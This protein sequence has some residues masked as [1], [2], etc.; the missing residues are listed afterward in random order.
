M[1]VA[2]TGATGLLGANLAAL[3]VEAGHQVVCTR[4]ASSDTSVLDGVPVT[5]VEAGLSDPEA[6]VRAFDGCERVFHCAAM[7]SLFRSVTPAL[8]A[9]NVAGTDH[10]VEACIRAGVP[11]LVHTS[12]TVAVGISTDG[13]PC[14]E[15]TRWNLPELGLDDGY[16][17]TKRRSEENVLRAVS[18]GRIDAV[19]VNPGFMFGPYD[20]RPSS[21]R[22]IVEVA[23]GR[24]RVFTRGRNCFVDA[25]NVAQGL[26]LAAD[27]GKRGERYILGDENLTYGAIFERIG[28][29]VGRPPPK[30]LAP[31]W[32]SYPVGRV[33]DLREW[34]TGEEQALTSMTLAWAYT[35]GFIA[36]HAKAV[37][38]LGWDPGSVDAGIRA[39][40]D[41]LRA[42]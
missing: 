31:R 32:L 36:S 39:C 20:A 7:T 10:V 19:V 11:R 29:V 23:A 18:D 30:F 25:R 15:T 12:S 4:R 37:R 41:W 16:A 35:P 34:W 21:G 2:I 17:T 1:K 22:M 40:W 5:W 13:V 6:L 3:A 27:C 42:R 9:S 24:A 26:L 33:G 14:D 38:E 8:E 28:H